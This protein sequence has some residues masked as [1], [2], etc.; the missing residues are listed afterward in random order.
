M[1][2]QFSLEPTTQE[3]TLPL[4][5]N[6][7]FPLLRLIAPFLQYY[8]P[9]KRK[10]ARLSTGANT[11]DFLFSFSFYP[12]SPP[13]SMTVSTVYDHAARQDGEVDDKVSWRAAAAPESAASQL[14][15][16]TLIYHW[17]EEQEHV[18]LTLLTSNQKLI[19]AQERLIK[20]AKYK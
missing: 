9:P 16:V 17:V 13:I 12:P 18:Q 1:P 19:E 2:R 6:S 20:I 14:P 4:S 11:A 5:V 8:Q 15:Q 3:I 7:T 10:M